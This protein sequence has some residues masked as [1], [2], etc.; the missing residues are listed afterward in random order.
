LGERRRD[1]DERKDVL[2]IGLGRFGSSL[3][4]TLIE[5]GHRVLA[6]DSSAQLVQRYAADLTHVVEGDAT[7]PEVLRQIG[8]AGMP[9]AAV[10]I[11]GDIEASILTTAALVD[12]GV[13]DIWAKAIT[14]AHGT[15]LERVGA[16]HVVF[17]EA[18][19]GE[20]VA[21]MLAGQ[22]LEY[23]ELDS[24]FVL[25][26]MPAPPELVGANL[27][28]RHLRDRFRVT[29]VCVKPAGGQFTYATAETVLCP[30]DLIVVAGHRNDV[31]RFTRET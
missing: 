30:D 23:V 6:I 15:I 20:R 25:A 9:I 27:A 26:E 14:T 21:H 10:C 7:N 18:D 28:D 5:M 2:V 4:Q 1:E 22:L 19:M 17:P 16:H 29:V 3:A 13:A 11:G 8:A 12:L 24:D 31:D